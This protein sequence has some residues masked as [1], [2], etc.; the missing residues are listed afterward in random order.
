MKGYHDGSRWLMI[1]RD[2]VLSALYMSSGNLLRFRSVLP[3][4]KRRYISPGLSLA[5][6]IPVVQMTVHLP[7]T[8]ALVAYRDCTAALSFVLSFWLH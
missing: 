6:E 4:V 2:Q 3:L 8:A 1:F 5:I 7:L